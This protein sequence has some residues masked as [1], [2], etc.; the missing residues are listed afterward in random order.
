VGELIGFVFGYEPACAR[1]PDELALRNRG[2]EP[3]R[4]CVIEPAIGFPP[5]DECGH[6]ECRE[7]DVFEVGAIDGC[8]EGQQMPYPVLA[9][10]WREVTCHEPP[11]HVRRVADASLEHRSQEWRDAEDAGRDAE[12]MAGGVALECAD[13]VGG[14]RFRRQ[15]VD[16]YQMRHPVG[17]RG[18]EPHG[19]GAAQIDAGYGC[20]GNP[21]GSER[22][23]GILRLGRDPEIGI[24]GPVGLT[25]TQ[26]I[27]GDCRMARLGQAGRDGSPEEPARSES[28]YQ[29]DRRA[30]MSVPFDM[31][32]ARTDRDSED[33]WL[34]ASLVRCRALCWVVIFCDAMR[35]V[36]AAE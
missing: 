31:D 2:C 20:P 32:R 8:G 9:D 30:S 19:D 21:E 14:R 13:I 24:E 16:E 12:D 29:N 1:E 18:C 28:V 33:I 26:Q 3:F 34:D 4:D 23:L 36:R 6:P 10:K 35:V 15:T 22:T 17:V 7:A 11:G 5:N 27:Q 25:V